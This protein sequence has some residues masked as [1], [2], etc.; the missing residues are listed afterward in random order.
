MGNFTDNKIGNFTHIYCFPICQEYTL[1][2]DATV[3]AQ[4]GHPLGV[5]PV[6]QYS[7]PFVVRANTPFG[8]TAGRRWDLLVTP[9]VAGA[10]PFLV[11]YIDLNNGRVHHIAQTVITVV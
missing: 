10:F 6:D 3:I 4:D 1:G 9:T 11:K 5:P 7:F 8:L 2:I